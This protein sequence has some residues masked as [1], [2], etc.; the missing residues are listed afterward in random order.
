MHAI[1]KTNKKAW[2]EIKHIQNATNILTV[3]SA[4]NDAVLKATSLWNFGMHTIQM[5]KSGITDAHILTI[6]QIRMDNLLKHKAA[7]RKYLLSYVPARLRTTIM[8]QNLIN[9][10]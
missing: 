2:L 8:Y 5:R 10:A 7:I 9:N 1:E 4:L 6:C 3:E